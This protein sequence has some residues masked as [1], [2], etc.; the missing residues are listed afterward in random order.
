MAHNIPNEARELDMCRR[1]ESGE[2][3]QAI[4][5]RYGVTRERV[6]QLINPH[7]FT[8]A[9]GGIHVVAEA[10]RSARRTAL[11]TRRNT[12]YLASYGCSYDDFR[13]LNQGMAASDTGSAAWAYRTQKFNAKR[14]SIPWEISFPEWIGLWAAVGGF[15]AR[16]R[17]RNGLVLGRID[18]SGPFTLANTCITSHATNSA[19]ARVQA[20]ARKGKQ[21]AGNVGSTSHGAVASRKASTPTSTRVKGKKGEAAHG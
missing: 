3:L 4:G 11:E 18:K 13:L 7:G 9:N 19:D 10:S 12:Q 8:G 17:F 2:T 1:Y 16:G 15:A 20:L 5:D 21:I 14:D 6:R